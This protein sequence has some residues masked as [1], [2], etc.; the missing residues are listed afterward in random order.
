MKLGKTWIRV[1]FG[2]NITC[3]TPGS[4]L[5]RFYPLTISPANLLTSPE[6]TLSRKY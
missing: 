1:A 5:L 3:L 4:D 2:S 6:S